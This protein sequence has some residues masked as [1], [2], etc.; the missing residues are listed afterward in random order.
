MDMFEKTINA[1]EG[2]EDVKI[3]NMFCKIGINIDYKYDTVFAGMVSMISENTGLLRI[4]QHAK[5]AYF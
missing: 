4:R 2:Y 1:I 5:Y 3:D